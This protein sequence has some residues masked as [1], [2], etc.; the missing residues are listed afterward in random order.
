MIFI[1]GSTGFLGRQLVARLLIEK[2]YETLGLLVRAKD[3]N[4]AKSR[5]IEVLQDIFET[6]NI[7]Y[8]LEKIKII[9]GNVELENFGLGVDEFTSLA[10]QTNEIFHSAACTNLGS[11]VEELRNS[12]VG[13]TQHI[14]DFALTAQKLNSNFK[15]LYHISTAYAVGD[16]KGT[17][18][19]ID[20]SLHKKFRNGY[21]QSKAEAEALVKNQGEQ[22]PYTIFRPSVIV[23]DSITGQTT[24]FNVIYIPAKCIALGLLNAIPALPKIPF[25]IVPVD[26]VA[27]T[28]IELRTHD[29]LHQHYHICAGVGRETNP[30]EI[31]DMIIKTVNFYR[32]SSKK[33]LHVP[34]LLSPEMM[35]KAFSTIAHA[36]EHI[37]H[38]EELVS[39]RILVISQ[40]L[41]FIPYLLSNPQFD[42]SYTIKRLENSKTKYC[43]LFPDYAENVFR[44]C[45][46]TNW[47]KKTW[48]SEQRTDTWVKRS[49]IILPT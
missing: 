23:G 1:T 41:P 45:L 7:N 24:A 32:A 18:L 31:L 8:L 2:P 14:L 40:I 46:E 49:G 29:T 17:V 25:D 22:L 44:Y 33:L 12:N 34:P 15:R 11:P 21:E 16:T 28:I 35:Y 38:L 47:G 39:K 37:R 5:I 10:S 36:K 13:G 43:P 26:F 4:S 48:N 30:K 9:R 3:Y 20:L 42:I 6:K 27:D 19:P